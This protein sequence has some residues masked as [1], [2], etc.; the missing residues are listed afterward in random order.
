MFALG[1]AAHDKSLEKEAAWQNHRANCGM[2]LTKLKRRDKEKAAQKRE[3]ADKTEEAE[4]AQ[5]KA[6]E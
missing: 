3:A 2:R 1:A 6:G 5:D 4:K